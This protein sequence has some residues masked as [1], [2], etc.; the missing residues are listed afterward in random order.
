MT[1]VA[2]NRPGTPS[3]IERLSRQTGIAPPYI[4]ARLG[5]HQLFPF[6]NT[7]T[8]L[9]E[10]LLVQETSFFRH[11]GQ[12]TML[13]NMLREDPVLSASAL[14]VWSTACAT[15]EEAWSLAFLL[16]SEGKGGSRVIGSDISPSAIAAATLGR[17]TRLEAM[18]SF[19]DL[20]EF[21]RRAFP[22]ASGEVWD[23]PGTLRNM[24]RF[25]VHNVLDPML[26]SELGGPADLVFCRNMLIYFT[27]DAVNKALANIASAM[28]TGAILVLGA[29]ETMRDNGLFEPVETASAIFWR[30]TGRPAVMP[31]PMAEAVPR[32]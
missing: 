20:P 7:P 2:P 8:D 9:I 3:L 32:P 5:P 13:R 6:Q 30:R 24:T 31:A 25:C 19:R 23:A 18:G 1:E 28:R 26:S 12:W 17:Y 21:A 27:E 4:G 11:A 10:R 29:S 15:G 16:Q 14:R 22:L